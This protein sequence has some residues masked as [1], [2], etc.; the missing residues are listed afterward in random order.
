M[1]GFDVLATL[2]SNSD[3]KIDSTDADWGDLQVW[4]DANGDAQTQ[5]SELYSLASL[6]ITQF[7]LTGVLSQNYNTPGGWIS[8]TGTFVR[9]VLIRGSFMACHRS[10]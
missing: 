8:H 4:V 7:N 2:D 6:D 5:A 3:G 9:D 1:N 10:S